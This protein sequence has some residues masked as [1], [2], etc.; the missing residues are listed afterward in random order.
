M[1]TPDEVRA[2]LL[3]SADHGRD[4][5]ARRKVADA[6]KV[7]VVEATDRFGAVVAGQCNTMI[8]SLRDG[9]PLPPRDRSAIDAALTDVALAASAVVLAS[10]LRAPAET[11]AEP[12]CSDGCLSEEECRAKRQAAYPRRGGWRAR[13]ANVERLLSEAMAMKP[14]GHQMRQTGEALA[15]VRA[16]I[17]GDGDE[18]G[19][20]EPEYVPDT[21]PM[22]GAD[23]NETRH[24]DEHAY[25]GCPRLRGE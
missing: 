10:D 20:P 16:M 14:S 2:S 11:R 4:G 12:V 19:P 24:G 15:E 17:D 22:C 3:S 18:P 23:L 25:D 21:C 1:A 13:L 7:V 5:C 8:E 9:R 6:V